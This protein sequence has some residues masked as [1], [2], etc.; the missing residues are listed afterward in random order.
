MVRDIGGDSVCGAGQA[1]IDDPRDFERSCPH[2]GN[3]CGAER[4]AVMHRFINVFITVGLF[5]PNGGLY[6]FPGQRGMH[7]RLT[8]AAR[9]NPSMAPKKKA[10]HVRL[11]AAYL[12]LL[13][14]TFEGPSFGRVPGRRLSSY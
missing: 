10:R 11:W 5:R 6:R 4:F 2:R 9:G 1:K 3:A 7:A 8:N 14:G 13:P 12:N